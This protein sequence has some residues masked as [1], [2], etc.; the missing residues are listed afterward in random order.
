MY[1]YPVTR[2][3]RQAGPYGP[4][5]DLVGP[6]PSQEIRDEM[7]ERAK[8][9]AQQTL[10]RKEQLLCQC[11]GPN[12]VEPSPVSARNCNAEAG[13]STATAKTKAIQ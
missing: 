3:M 12:A 6:W 10:T 9:L 4:Y 1:Y 11:T 5:L 2:E 7:S 13:S 8:E